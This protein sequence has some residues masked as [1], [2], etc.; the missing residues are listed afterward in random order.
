MLW[1]FYR[2]FLPHLLFSLVKLHSEKTP[3]PLGILGHP[4]TK[5]G[6]S[7]PAKYLQQNGCQRFYT[8]KHDGF[9]VI[10]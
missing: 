3:K 9:P 5:Q 6:G 2:T 4:D 10:S 7:F 8:L 1:V